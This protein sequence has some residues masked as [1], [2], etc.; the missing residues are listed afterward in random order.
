MATRDDIYAA[1]RNADKAGDTESV[2]KLAAYLQ[3]MPPDG[4]PV[5]QLSAEARRAAI[6]QKAAADTAAWAAGVT[7]TD[8]MSGLERFVAGMG[9]GT[10]DLVQGAGQRLGD[11]VDFVAPAPARTLS[12]LITNQAPPT[13]A[14]RIGLPTSADVAESRRID[15]PLMATAAGKAGNIVGKVAAAIPTA[16]IPGA[17][18]L[19]GAGAIGAGQGALEPTTADESVLK[20]MAM[21]AAGG[22]A[23]VGVGK[24]VGA[25]V[26]TVRAAAQPFYEA[27]QKQIIGRAL[28]SAAGADA[29][30]VGNQLERAAAPFVG[31]S[32]PGLARATMGELVPG[33][34]LTVGQAAQNP[35]I[36]ALERA[37]VA[38]QPSV[39]NQVSAQ[40]GAQN[41]ARA[42]VLSDMAGSGGARDF[43]AAERAGTSDLLYGAARANGV[44]PAALTPE[45]QANIAAMQSRIPAPI[46]AEAKS[47]A[48]INGMPM[49]D[50]TVIAGMHYVKQA[51]DDAISSAKASGNSTRAAALTGLQKDYLAGMD[52]LSPDYAAARATHA[53]MSE[54]INQMDVAQALLNKAQNPL[55]GAVQPAAF[56]RALTDKTAAGA[57]G[58]AGATL[59]NTM[60]NQ[61]QN[62]LQSILADLQRSNAAN[63]AGR[64]VGSDTVQKLAYGNILDQS[65][66]PTFLR[67]LSPAQIVGNV[68]ARGAD[69]AYGRANKELSNRLAETML[70]PAD[71]AE[72]MRLANESDT[73][74]ALLKLL[75]PY[76]KIAARTTAPVLLTG[77]K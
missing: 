30:A 58:F 9:K 11:A 61:Q 70:S 68:A 6:H 48:Q 72:A 55:T 63:T 59:D 18:G 10:H 25:G 13:M 4:A 1:I 71:A 35:G 20:N 51:I 73:P 12:S 62:L 54:P 50:S 8:G 53:A 29:A 64:G 65:G 28:N 43:A 69:V 56:A 39:T 22:A 74:N 76:L 5:D 32:Q 36:A 38:T 7:P 3:T 67:E 34:V 42:G 26:R 41:A 47:L 40:L 31:P 21:G 66:V 52:Q 57:T 14:A 23:G 16:F 15:A 45:A 19:V 2:Q 27:G 33:S 24:L 60:T 44:N 46:L 75:A 49:D 77:Q 17:N 37:A